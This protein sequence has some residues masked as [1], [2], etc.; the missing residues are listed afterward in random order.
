MITDVVIDRI[1]ATI[2]N[3]AKI[4]S[5]NTEIKVRG[6]DF[7][8]GWMNVYFSWDVIYASDVGYLKFEGRAKVLD[9][10]VK[11]NAIKAAWDSKHEIPGE[12]VEEITNS[13]N[14][15]CTLNSA[16]V[17]RP[18]NIAPPIKMQAVSAVKAK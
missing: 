3:R 2:F 17:V 6:A 13:I 4:D 1:D 5:F 14:Y 8:E 7:G 12:F 10:P 9:S 16:F 11:I 18:M 15:F